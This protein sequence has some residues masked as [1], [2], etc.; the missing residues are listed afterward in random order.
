MGMTRHEPARP[1]LKAARA[2]PVAAWLTEDRAVP[3]LE[4]LRRVH[5]AG[6]A[7]GKSALYELIRGLRPT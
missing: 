2:Y 1:V 7:G 4:I 5:E 6:Y 3:D